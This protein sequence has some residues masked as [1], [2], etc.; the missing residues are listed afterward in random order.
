MP[1]LRSGVVSLAAVALLGAC[2]AG[3][4]DGPG[5]TCAGGTVTVLAASSLGPALTEAGTAFRESTGCD[6]ELRVSTGSSTSLAGQIVGGAP[7]DVFVAAGESAARSVADAVDGA[8]EPLLFAANVAALMTRDPSVAS[9]GDLVTARSRGVT[10]GLCVSSAPCGAL[11][12]EV[13]AKTAPGSAR[14]LIVSTEAPSAGDL[15]AKI[16]MGEVDAGI[17][18]A[19]DCTGVASPVRCSDIPDAQNS[20]VGYLAVALR[21]GAA[22]RQFVRFLASPDGSEFLGKYGFLAP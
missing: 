12:D 10:V 15:R 16:M 2:G 6:A 3:D 21:D 8:G 5:E 1:G 11:A 13:L 14:D 9:V 22:A 18:F 4:T 7:A 20:R 19:S 17:V